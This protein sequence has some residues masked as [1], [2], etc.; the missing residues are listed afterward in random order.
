MGSI[1]THN[2]C[3]VVTMEMYLVR[4]IKKICTWTGKILITINYYYYLIT[5]IHIFIYSTNK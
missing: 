3:Y 2:Y 4:E 5:S 1:E